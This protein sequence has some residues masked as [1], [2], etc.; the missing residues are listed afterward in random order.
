MSHLNGFSP[1]WTKQCIFRFPF[2]ENVLSHWSQLYLIPE[3]ICLLIIN[4]EQKE[5]PIHLFI[6]ARNKIKKKIIILDFSSDFF[7]ARLFYN[8]GRSNRPER[9]A[10]F[11][12][13]VMFDFSYRFQTLYVNSCSSQ[14][15]FRKSSNFKIITRMSVRPF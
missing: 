10:F 9:I 3:C 1:V 6:T 15:R 7:K 12:N 8:Q 13:L 2:W 5:K 14:V 4:I 11:V